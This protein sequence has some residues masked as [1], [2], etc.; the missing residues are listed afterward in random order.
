MSETQSFYDGLSPMRSAAIVFDERHYAPAPLDWWLAL[1]DIRGSTEAV[2]GGRHANVNFAAAAM[3]AA[4]VNLCGSI[5]YQFGGDGAV[6]LVPPEHEA[7]ARRVLARTRGFAAREFG[8]DL[9]VGIVKVAMLAERAAA[10]LVGATSRRP[11]APTP[12]FAAAASP[13]SSGR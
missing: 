13:C 12:C 5:P 9:R 10:V 7:E 8:L 4:L 1:S 11:A 3:I 6:A 2:A